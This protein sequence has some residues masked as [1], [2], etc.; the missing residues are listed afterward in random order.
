MTKVILDTD[1]Y[2]EIL[3]AKNV[4]LVKKA[5]AYRQQ[6]G[7]YTLTAA[8]IVELVAGLQQQGRHDRLTALLQSLAQERILTLDRPAAIL[9]GQMHGELL[10]TGQTIGQIDPMIAGI[11]IRRGLTLVT[12]NTQHYERIVRLGFPLRLDNWR[13]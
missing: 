8:T 1:T 13:L 10:R 2:S 9:A 6:F 4:A 12:G 3:R 7:A 5:I 11:A